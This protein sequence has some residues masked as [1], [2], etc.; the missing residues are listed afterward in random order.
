MCF[1]LV[2]ACLS[3]SL[4]D[5]SP[6]TPHPYLS[7]PHWKQSQKRHGPQV[8]K[9]HAGKAAP[10]WL[11]SPICVFGCVCACIYTGNLCAIMYKGKGVHCHRGWGRWG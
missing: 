3:V 10:L 6:A 8:Q 1:S 2:F 4:G 9:E 11:Q 5:G 7:A